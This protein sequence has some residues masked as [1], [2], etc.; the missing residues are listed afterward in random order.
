MSVIDNQKDLVDWYDNQE[1]VLTKDFLATIRWNQIKNHPV[2][3][4]FIPVL[5]YFRDVEKFTDIYFQQ[6]IIMIL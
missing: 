2:D 3:E 6:G 5:I 4:S 1:R